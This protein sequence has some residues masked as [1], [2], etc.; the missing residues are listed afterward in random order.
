MGQKIRYVI[1][2]FAICLCVT[3]GLASSQG[4]WYMRNFSRRPC[5]F[6]TARVWRASC[7]RS[8]VRSILRDHISRI[9]NTCKSIHR[10]FRTLS[11]NAMVCTMDGCQCSMGPC[12]PNA[13]FGS[14]A[15]APSL[16][17]KWSSHTESS[18]HI[19]ANSARRS[20]RA[21]S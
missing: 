10:L 8:A 7:W 6:S 18:R 12:S 4:S 14:M 9:K 2:S 17:T 16:A 1:S 11:D 15:E 3:H 20:E 19:R 21:A 5:W 13:I